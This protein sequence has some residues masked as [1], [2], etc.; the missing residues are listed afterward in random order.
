MRHFS[1]SL[2]NRSLPFALDCSIGAFALEV[3]RPQL[4]GC[5]NFS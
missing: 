3:L 1:E 2:I 4:S 5:L